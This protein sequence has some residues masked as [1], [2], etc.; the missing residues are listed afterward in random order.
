MSHEGKM[1][2]GKAFWERRNNANELPDGIKSNPAKM[3]DLNYY[4]EN[5]KEKKPEDAAPTKKKKE[6]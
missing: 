6:K 4:L 5:S 3:A 2:R 1:R